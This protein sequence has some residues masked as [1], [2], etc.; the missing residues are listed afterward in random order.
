MRYQFPETRPLYQGCFH[1]Q[2]TTCRALH[3][4]YEISLP[5]HEGLSSW[6][7]YARCAYG[8]EEAQ[9]CETAHQDLTSTK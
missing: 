3:L 9:R 8:G 1:H 4:T 7:S 6:C 5:P 2:P